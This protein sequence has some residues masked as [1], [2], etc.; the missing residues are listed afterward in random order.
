[1]TGRLEPTSV[2]SVKRE[3][4]GA[5]YRR[6]ETQAPVRLA[7]SVVALGCGVFAGLVLS[8]L[9]HVV[10]GCGVILVAGVVGRVAVR[11]RG[12]VVRTGGLRWSHKAKGVIE[13][14]LVG[15]GGS[16]TADLAR[17]ARQ[18]AS[19]KDQGWRGLEVMMV[20][21]VFP[22]IWLR[23]WGFS[24]NECGERLA[25]SY[26]GIYRLKWIEWS[27]RSWCKGRRGPRYRRRR[28]IEARHAL[29]E[30]FD[31]IDSLPEGL[32]CTWTR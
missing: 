23:S 15:G 9:G 7:V 26:R 19:L 10:E 32:R 27:I 25:G 1:M 29:G 14:E 31:V 24:V 30:W 3:R 21:A 18:S 11:W 5:F 12:E 6:V 8:S 22:P 2:W 16:W 17:V 28:C 13:V 4:L 20:T